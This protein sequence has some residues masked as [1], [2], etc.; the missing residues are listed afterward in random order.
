MPSVDYQSA[1]EGLVHFAVCVHVLRV[2]STPSPPP[3]PSSTIMAETTAT[4][5]ALLVGAGLTAAVLASQNTSATNDAKSAVRKAPGDAADA[6]KSFVRSGQDAVH[7]A[8]DAVKRN[9]PGGR[10]GV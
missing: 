5:A 7:G 10:G 4:A 2:F 9:L 8:A 3:S 6:T 1:S